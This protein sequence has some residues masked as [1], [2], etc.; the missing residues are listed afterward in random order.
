MESVTSAPATRPVSAATAGDMKAQ[1][2]LDAT[3]PPTQPL[4][5]SEASGRPKRALVTTA[6][7]RADM[8]ADSVVLTTISTAVPGAAPANN[9]A[10]LAFSP[11]HP[12][13][14]RKQDSSTK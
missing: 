1:P 8:P 10:P 4:A 13:H 5:Q 6:A 14:T 12:N 11:H 3:R 9:M 2:A 7:A